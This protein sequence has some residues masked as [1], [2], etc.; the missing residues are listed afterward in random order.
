MSVTFD[1]NDEVVLLYRRR[2]GVVRVP[3]RVSSAIVVNGTTVGY[4]VSSGSGGHLTVGTGSLLPGT[5]LDRIN[6]ALSEDG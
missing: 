2:D 4:V 3:V 5:V 6:M 1:A